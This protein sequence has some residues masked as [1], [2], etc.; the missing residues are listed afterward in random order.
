MARDRPDRH[1]GASNHSAVLHGVFLD[2]LQVGVFITGASGSG[3]SELALDLINRGH[4]LIAEDMPEFT[5]LPSRIVEAKGS[6]PL[7][8]FLEVRGL[9]VLNIRRMF[10]DDAIRP[11][12]RLGLVINMINAEDLVL[13]PEMRLR[14]ARTITT[15][16]GVEF[17][18]ITLPSG[19]AR[20]LAVLVECAVRDHI[21]RLQGYHAERDLAQRLQLRMATDNFPCE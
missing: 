10:G 6:A 9:G 7:C 2:V 11:Q 16:L 12:Q 20:N 1:K 8:D 15:I 21:L 5:R 18:Q 14:G 13:S 17:P 3:K 4:R 19:I